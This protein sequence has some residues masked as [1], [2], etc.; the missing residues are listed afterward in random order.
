MIKGLSDESV[1]LEGL[2]SKISPHE[3]LMQP[4]EDDEKHEAILNF[5]SPL[6]LQTN[7]RRATAEEFTARKLLML[8]V[9]RIALIHEF[10]GG[11]ALDLDF[12]AM[13]VL[14]DKIECEKQL[15]WRDWA[16]YSNRQQQK[17]TLGGVVGSWKLSGDLQPFLA[18]LHLGQWLHVGKEA[19]FGLGGYT[20]EIR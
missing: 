11:H 12:K 15:K 9:K 14:A 13:A 8:L 7:G 1:V 18:F 6:R 17:M 5:Y 20:L 10:H 16:R 3:T 2:A 4:L 19:A